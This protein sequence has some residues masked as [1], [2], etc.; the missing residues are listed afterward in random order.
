MNPAPGGQRNPYRGAPARAWLF[1]SLMAPDGTRRQFDLVA[2][3]GCHY[4]LVISSATL[5]HF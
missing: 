5:S 1:A 4:D 3:T 2:D